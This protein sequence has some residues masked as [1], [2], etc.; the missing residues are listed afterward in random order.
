MNNPKTELDYFDFTLEPGK[1]KESRLSEYV[2]NIYVSIITHYE[3]QGYIKQ[4]YNS[5]L[6]QTF[7]H[8]EWLIAT[9]EIDE[10][11]NELVKIDKRIRIVKLEDDESLAKAQYIAAKEAKSDLLLL[12]CESDLI[13]KTMLECGYFT[14]LTNPE[15]V[16]AY[17]RMVDC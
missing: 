6:N 5:L 1:N 17:S 4:T 15:G 8:W 7:P 14:M 13:D 3:N 2:D 9:H 12:L 11:L 16:W 10:T